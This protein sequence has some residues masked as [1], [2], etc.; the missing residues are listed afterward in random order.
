MSRKSEKSKRDDAPILTTLQGEKYQITA[1]RK[2]QEMRSYCRDPEITDAQFRGLFVVI[3][4]LNDG[5]V[6]EESRWGSAYPSYETLATDIGKDERAAKRIIK[7]L[8]T[9]QRETRSKDK[10]RSLVPCKAVLNVKSAKSGKTDEVNEYRLKTLGAF[11]VMDESKG[12]VTEQKD[13]GPEGAVTEQHSGGGAVTGKEGCG[14]LLEGVRSP[15]GRGAVTAPDSSRLLTSATQHIDPS[16]APPASGELGPA[17]SDDVDDGDGD[18]SRQDDPP[19]HDDHR[20]EE[21]EDDGRL[22]QYRQAAEKIWLMF[23]RAPTREHDEFVKLFVE[24]CKAGVITESKQVKHGLTCY[25]RDTPPDR[26]VYPVRFMRERRWQTYR[27]P[28]AGTGKTGT[29]G[30]SARPAI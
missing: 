20:S 22:E 25:M 24:E 12:A 7:E 2:L 8:T 28:P 1:G 6:G 14:N 29:A 11:A 15:V 16:H 17:G 19:E 9:G 26:H 23:Q 27:Q 18:E 10:E 5:R 30:Y 3:D 4:R 13:A 21:S